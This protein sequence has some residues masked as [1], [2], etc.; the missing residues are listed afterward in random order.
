[1]VTFKTIIEKFKKQGEKTG[2]TYI[3]ISHKIAQKINPGIKT[4][5]RIKGSLDQYTFTGLNILP[6]GEGNF[7]LP[8]N[9]A[10]RKAIR[11][12]AGDNLSV[13]IEKDPI[14]YQINSE[15]MECLEAEPNAL[16]QFKSMPGSH[17]NYFSKWIES[18]KTIN[19][20]HDR[21][22]RTVNAM[23]KKQGYAEMMREK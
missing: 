18:A 11:K 3:S 8:L 10:I 1:M 20:R 4:S 21:I 9:A 7:I 19:T 12:T 6:M 13:K 16:A 15:L 17:Q 2:W 5:Y 22:A 14:S 23:I